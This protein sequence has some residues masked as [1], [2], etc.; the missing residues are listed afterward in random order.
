MS[1]GPFAATVSLAVAASSDQRALHE[2]AT[3]LAGMLLRMDAARTLIH[4]SPE[5][6]QAILDEGR[7][8]GRSAIGALREALRDGSTSPPR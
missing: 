6:A 3:I 1:E 7:R 4:S 2:A 5:A 8:A